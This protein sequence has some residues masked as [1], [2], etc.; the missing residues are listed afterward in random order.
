MCLP[1]RLLCL[2][3]AGAPCSRWF[4]QVY[5][6]PSMSTPCA[7]TLPTL[8][9]PSPDGPF[10]GQQALSQKHFLFVCPAVTL[11]SAVTC[12]NTRTVIMPTN[13]P[14]VNKLYV[15]E[16]LNLQVRRNPHALK[17]GNSTTAQGACRPAPGHNS[18]WPYRARLLPNIAGLFYILHTPTNT[19]QA[20]K[21][22]GQ[23][24]LA[25]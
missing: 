24:L 15:P 22:F 5:F 17:T 18:Q 23:K 8:F 16:R 14:L 9:W 13:P 4:L 19:P 10:Y 2:S 6:Q 1:P 11:S 20:E 3:C 12:A 21:I 7:V 25:A